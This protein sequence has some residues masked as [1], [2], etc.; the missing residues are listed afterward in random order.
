MSCN[1]GIQPLP[2][3]STGSDFAIARAGSAPH[4]HTVDLAPVVQRL[5]NAIYRINPY[6]MVSVVCF[7]NT[8]PLDSVIQPLNYEGLSPL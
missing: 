1:G 5:D 6:P 2:T 7:V 8:Y 4:V 3:D